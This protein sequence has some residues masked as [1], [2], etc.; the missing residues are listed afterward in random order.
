MILVVD[1]D[2]LAQ[3]PRSQKSPEYVSWVRAPVV[4]AEVQWKIND[5][6]NNKIAAPLKVPVMKSDQV[7]FVTFLWNSER[8]M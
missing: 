6:Q 4:P 2:S 3:P 8:A 1:R 5:S 7:F